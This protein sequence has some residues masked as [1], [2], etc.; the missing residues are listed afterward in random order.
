MEP[1]SSCPAVPSVAL[2]SLLGIISDKI[3]RDAPCVSAL[4]QGGSVTAAGRAG[5]D[6][7]PPL[8]G[9][10]Q[11]KQYFPKY[12]APHLAELKPVKHQ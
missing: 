9:M 12:H 2:L 7:Q 4:K 5:G 11:A 6:R 1:G 3:C 10:C 8:P